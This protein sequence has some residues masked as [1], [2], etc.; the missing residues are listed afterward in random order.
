MTVFSIIIGILLIAGGIGLAVTPLSTF[1][2]SG[3]FI[4]ILFFLCGIVGIIR[5]IAKKQYG[6]EFVFAI[7]SLVLGII[8]LAVPGVALMNNYII[9]YMAA[10]WFFVR[11]ILSI[12]AA[13][14]S[15]KLGAGTGILVL[16]IILGILEIVLGCYSIAYPIV[17]AIALG[18]LIGFYFIES[19]INMIV[20]GSLFSSGN[21]NAGGR[22]A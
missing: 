19:G 14:Q 5:G 4:I 11:G 18:L 20:L 17:L 15:R 2:A 6:I 1:L 9:L 8:G 13:I 10:G 22:P 3:Y 12:V 16:G 7:I 21:S